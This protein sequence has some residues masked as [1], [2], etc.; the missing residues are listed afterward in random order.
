[1]LFAFA[2]DDWVVLF[3]F[4]DDWSW[5]TSSPAPAPLASPPPADWSW[6]FDWSVSLL[7]SAFA[8]VSASLSWLTSPLNQRL[9]SRAL[10]V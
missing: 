2:V 6:S 5:W 9:H 8:F 7:F 3:V 4:P 1:V 10:G